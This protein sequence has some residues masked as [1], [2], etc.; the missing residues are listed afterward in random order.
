MKPGTTLIGIAAVA[1]GF[2]LG[3]GAG[4]TNWLAMPDLEAEWLIGFVGL[5]LLFVPYWLFSR[6]LL[7]RLARWLI[8]FAAAVAGAFALGIALLV[9]A[10]REIVH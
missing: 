6:G 5:V 7:T 2:W 10:I 1:V 9:F 4:G 3:G 8:S